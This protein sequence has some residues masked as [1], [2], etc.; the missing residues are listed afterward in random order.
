MDRTD[1]A[2]RLTSPAEGA[3]NPTLGL[4]FARDGSPLP[5]RGNTVICH[6]PAT[7]PELPAL[8]ELAQRLRGLPWGGRFAFLPASSYHMTVFEGVTDAERAPERW[9]AGIAADAPLEDIACRFVDRLRGLAVPQRFAMRPVGL[10]P[11]GTGG[12]V[13]GLEPADEDTARQIRS[14]REAFA[15]TLIVLGHL[16]AAASIASFTRRSCQSA[17][18]DSRFAAA[19]RRSSSSSS[20]VSRSERVTTAIRRQ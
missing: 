14:L 7:A 13:V 17:C 9:P 8:A 4:K 12:T 6:I 16:K 11:M 10:V 1:L 3:P 18:A 5:F 19:L 15:L 2:S 20:G